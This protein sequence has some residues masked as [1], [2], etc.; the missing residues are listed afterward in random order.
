MPVTLFNDIEI[1]RTLT[2]SPQRRKKTTT[3]KWRFTFKNLTFS[4]YLSNE[5][6]NFTRKEQIDLFQEMIN[7][8]KC[9]EEGKITELKTLEKGEF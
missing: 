4:S 3:F 2:D 7:T 1:Q 5:N 8:M 6:I 9:I